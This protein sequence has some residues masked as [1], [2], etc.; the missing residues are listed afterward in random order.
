MGKVTLEYVYD[1]YGRLTD[2]TEGTS[3][4]SY[5]YNKYGE[6]SDKSYENGQKI[7]YR[8]DEYGRTAQISVLLN[9]KEVTSTKYVYDNMNR[10]TRVIAHDG[11]A[12][13]YTYDAV[14]K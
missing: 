3:H 11:T 10:L 4:I 9:N 5:T 7:S 14:I 2:V 8:Y 12:T 13:V 1:S 6:L